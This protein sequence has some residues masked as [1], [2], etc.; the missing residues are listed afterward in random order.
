[1]RAKVKDEVTGT[2]ESGRLSGCV[3]LARRAR[4]ARERSPRV[5]RTPR[6]AG[7]RRRAQAVLPLRAMTLPVRLRPLVAT[8]V[9][10]LLLS[11]G[12][13]G[14]KAPSDAS[15]YD[16]SSAPARY[17]AV[18]QAFASDVR[19]SGAPGAS[20]GIVALAYAVGVG[21]TAPGG[22]VRV[23]PTT[24]FRIG[25]VTKM[26]TALAVLQEVQAG[27]VALD[28]A[29]VAHVPG[30]HLAADD[31]S[32][33]TVRELL[34][35]TAALSDYLEVN[36]PAG[37]KGDDAL[38][39]FLTGR[40][41]DLDYLMAPP[42]IFYNYSNPNF[43]L[44][45]LVAETTSSLPYRQLMDER[46][47]GPL[48]MDRTFFLPSDVLADGDF[49]VGA[50]T[51]EPAAGIPAVVRPDSY[52]NGWG[53]PAGYAWSSPADLARFA[54]FLMDGDETVLSPTLHALMTSPT[55]DTQEA[56][57]LIRYG[58]GLQGTPGFFL[59]GAWRPARTLQ[60]DGAIAGFSSYVM[61]LP[62]Q[63]FAVIMLA[64]GDGAAPF[65]QTLLAALRLPVLPAP[66]AGPDLAPD[67]STFA[68]EAGTYEDPHLAGTVTVTLSG[69]ALRVDIPA[70]TAAGISYDAVLVPSSPR[71]F[72]ITIEGRQFPLTFIHGG[73]ADPTWLRTRLFVAER[74]PAGSVRGDHPAPPQDLSAARFAAALRS[75]R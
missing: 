20:L 19:A 58:Y 44:A 46:V 5:S 49:A 74:A 70:A 47:F 13:S 33:V 29:V 35:H 64:S 57:D 27:R 69:G 63:R 15:F 21:R 40:F 2:G 60:H 11:C 68:E 1:M 12:G 39:A 71:N 61:V 3:A 48:G 66:T 50:T 31:V 36:A 72:L 62:E 32:G 54:A 51:A 75:V 41:A 24:L 17:A 65:L 6:R 53:R 22:D 55:R 45:G 8:A 18:A 52:D 42:G 7:R 9:L 14:S 38:E 26:M 34:E 30:F 67:S 28:D 43:M 37:E 16:V 56:L 4:Q 25:S 23:A 10:S 59:D 73:P